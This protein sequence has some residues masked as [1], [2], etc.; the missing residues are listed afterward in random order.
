MIQDAGGA[1][2]ELLLI[3]GDNLL[4]A[5]RG[6]R[7]QGGT[8]WLLPN[9]A[10]WRRDGVRI[11]VVFDGH[12]APGEPMRQRALGMEIRH[13]GSR[14]ADD[15]II[16]LLSAMPY[17]ERSRAAVV[18]RDRGLRDRVGQV[19]AQTRTP[20]WLL[21]GIRDAQ[22]RVSRGAAAGPPVGIGQGRVPR[23]TGPPTPSDDGGE[24]QPWRPGRGA[25]RK[26]GN[27]SREAKPGRHR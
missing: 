10:R 15:A 5:V 25:T 27:P 17:A 19:R 20:D 3:D 6:R 12:P 14:S 7:D 11:I 18:T 16:E 2:L 4:H 24:R 9:L 26:R 23:P 1:D 22:R 21:R 8:A 13:A